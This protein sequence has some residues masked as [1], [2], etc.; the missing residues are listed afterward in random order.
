MALEALWAVAFQADA[1]PYG[2]GVVV[3]ESNRIFGGDSC[4]YY[5]GTYELNTTIIN[6]KIKVKHFAGPRNNIFGP[7]DELSLN[8]RL[9]L[10]GKIITGG[11][12]SRECLVGP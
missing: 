6:A 9:Q 4:Y 3:F 7:V 5:V 12:P 8:L 1:G 10:E 11:A 2:A